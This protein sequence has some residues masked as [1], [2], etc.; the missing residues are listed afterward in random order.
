[1]EGLHDDLVQFIFSFVGFGDVPGRNMV[2]FRRI[3]K[4]YRDLTTTAVKVELDQHKQVTLTDFLVHF[5][6]YKT[7]IQ[8]KRNRTMEWDDYRG[9]FIITK[10]E[11]DRWVYYDGLLQQYFFETSSGSFPHYQGKIHVYEFVI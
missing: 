4:R 5:P 6:H 10:I 8:Q 3:S 1:M 9:F 7:E 2:S 11:R